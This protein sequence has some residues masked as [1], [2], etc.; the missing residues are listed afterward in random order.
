MKSE[1]KK[2]LFSTYV[3]VK[4]SD[5]SYKRIE[6]EAY[7]SGRKVSDVIREVLYEKFPPTDGE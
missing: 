7:K 6:K 4:I 3:G 1:R 2:G 5:I